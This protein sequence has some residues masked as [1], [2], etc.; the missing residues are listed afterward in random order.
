MSLGGDTLLLADA[1]TLRFNW[2]IPDAGVVATRAALNAFHSGESPAGVLPGG[3]LVLSSAGIVGRQPPR[4]EA[5]VTVASLT[6][7]TAREVARIPDLELVMVETRY[8]GRVRNLAQP[9]QLTRRA[10]IVV[11]DTVI[12]VATGDGYRID[13]LSSSGK[14]VGS[15][16]MDRAR[17]AVTAAMRD[18]VIARELR[19]FDGPHR[20]PPVDPAETRRL[21]RAAPFADSLPPYEGLFVTPDHRLWVVDPIAPTDAGWSATAFRADG[22]IVARLEVPE[23]SHPMAFGNDRVVVRTEDTDGVVA[24]KVY[25]IVRAMAVP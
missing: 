11:W 21:I 20:E 8:R 1:A 19:R 14:T 7:D 24:L 2:I 23:R 12:A 9:L 15:I 18:S 17:R 6:G 5:L 25:R 22:A 10:S 13:L 16:R 4:S 3:R